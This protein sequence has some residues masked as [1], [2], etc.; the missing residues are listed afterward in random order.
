MLVSLRI[1]K[2]IGS[3]AI[4]TSTMTWWSVAMRRPMAMSLN[5][6]STV[7]RAMSSSI[8]RNLVVGTM[9]S[10]WSLSIPM[11]WTKTRG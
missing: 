3:L 7:L 1:Y 8:S 10:E 5:R 6:A 11:R 2:R 9:A 4:L